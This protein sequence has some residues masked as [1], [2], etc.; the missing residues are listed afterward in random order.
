M[1]TT[2]TKRRRHRRPTGG[3][4]TYDTRPDRVSAAEE[5]RIEL[6]S[7]RQ[8]DIDFEPAW[9]E[10]TLHV[11]AMVPEGRAGGFDQRESWRVVFAWAEPKFRLGYERS[12]TT[13]THLTPEMLHYTD[14]VAQRFLEQRADV[15]A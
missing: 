7:L 5:L 2:P 1:A 15:V 10:A 3:A 13:I 8:R 6:A 11:L 14:G 9:A 4:H 12:P